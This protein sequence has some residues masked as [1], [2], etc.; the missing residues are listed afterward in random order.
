[1]R[2]KCL[3]GYFIFQETLRGDLSSF[4]SLTGL[5]LV[6]HRTF[7]TFNTIKDSPS[8]SLLGKNIIQNAIAI[9]TFEGEPWDIFKEN[10]IVYDFTKDLVVPIDSITLKAKIKSG[11]KYLISSGLILPGS[12]TDDGQRVTDYSA[13]YSQGQSTWF[14]TEV[15]YG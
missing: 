9:K 12:I 14:Y 10:K 13:W 2:I 3:H 6:P 11:G 7:F 8:Y 1:M 5:D 4:L 15:R